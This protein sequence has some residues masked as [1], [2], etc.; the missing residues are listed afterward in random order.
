MTLTDVLPSLASLWMWCR[1]RSLV[2]SAKF[3]GLKI[4]NLS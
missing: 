1:G 3:N 2:K 4:A